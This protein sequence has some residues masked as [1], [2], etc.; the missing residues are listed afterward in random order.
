MSRYL[1]ADHILE[2]FNVFHRPLVLDEVAGFVAEME[3]KSVDE[4]RLAVDNTLTAGWMHGFL[5]L[6]DGMFTLVCDY[7]GDG[8]S[9]QGRKSRRHV[10]KPKLRRSW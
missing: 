9:I 4:V 1:H 2:A 10:A 3:A 7:W 8:Q 5:D 6:E